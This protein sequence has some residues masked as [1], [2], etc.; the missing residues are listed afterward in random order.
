MNLDIVLC[1]RN[2]EALLRVDFIG[3]PRW[4][5]RTSAL[6]AWKRARGWFGYPPA[7]AFGGQLD[8]IQLFGLL[9]GRRL[10]GRQNRP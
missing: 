9:Y 8:F 10:F 1:A 6:G 7:L 3:V 2:R 5:Y 4:Q